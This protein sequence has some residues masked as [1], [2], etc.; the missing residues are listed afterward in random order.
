[1]HSISNPDFNT[2]KRDRVQH[3]LPF[4][5]VIAQQYFFATFVSLHFHSR[6]EVLERV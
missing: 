1:M 6:K 3:D 2:L 4:V 5:C